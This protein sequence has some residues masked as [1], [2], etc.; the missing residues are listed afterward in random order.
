MCRRHSRASSLARVAFSYRRRTQTNRTY[1]NCEYTFVTKATTLRRQDCPH[2]DTNERAHMTKNYAALCE[3]VTRSEQV[4]SREGLA[5][6][7]TA[8]EKCMYFL[9]VCV[10]ARRICF[11]CAACH[12]CGSVVFCAMCAPHCLAS[13][14]WACSCSPYAQCERNAQSHSRGGGLLF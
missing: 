13:G 3:C 2:T 11:M 4:R 10:C 7:F 9:F 6:K 5:T 8:L 1:I 12:C 14:W